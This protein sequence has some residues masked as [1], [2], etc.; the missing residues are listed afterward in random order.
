MAQVDA[1][2]WQDRRVA[3][4][5]GHDQRPLWRHNVHQRLDDRDRPA[6]DPAQRTQRRVDDQRHTRRHAQHAQITS[7]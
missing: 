2:S 3:R 6:A 5:R 4:L 1:T 7:E